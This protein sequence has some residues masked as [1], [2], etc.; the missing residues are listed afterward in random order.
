MILSGGSGT[1]LWPLSLDSRPKQFLELVGTS[2][3][4]EETLTRV[5][6]IPHA[7]RPIIVTGLQHLDQTLALVTDVDAEIVLEPEGRNT[8]AAIVAAAALLSADDMMVITPSDQLVTDS[9]G[10]VDAVGDAIAMAEKGG[11]GTLGVVPDRPESGFG[12]IQ[13]GAPKDS[14]FD[15][16][17][18][19][20]K[21]SME[22]AQSLIDG[23]SLWNAGIFV[24]RAGVIME[25]ARRLSPDLVDSVTAA[26]PDDRGS[27][28]HLGPSF[29]S[30]RN[31]PFDKEIMERTDIG[32]V[33]PM[34]AG[35]SDVGSWKAVWEVAEKDDDGNAI[36][37]DAGV[38]ESKGS[39][40]RTSSRPVLV[41]GVS[42]LAVV[43]TEE[44]LLITALD[45]SQDVRRFAELLKHRVAE[46]GPG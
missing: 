36:H 7:V 2:S 39:Y 9:V 29:L 16:A 5:L 30:S 8:A 18:F 1:R 37:G 10:F 15:I 12:Y 38:A 3:L 40:I 22:V 28:V 17:R 19:V 26:I 21:P 32:F 44:G 35:W 42:G 6:S 23:H 24:G 46:D 13:P 33:V 14:G 45:S 20:E 11:I 41:I 4:F 34:S 25:E 31:E 27:V 43:D